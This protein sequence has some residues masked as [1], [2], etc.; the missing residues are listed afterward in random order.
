M[1]F[2]CCLFNFVFSI[3]QLFYFILKQRIQA[4]ELRISSLKTDIPTGD[5]PDWDVLYR[6]NE[7]GLSKTIV[8]NSVL[9]SETISMNKLALRH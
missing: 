3:A 6:S 8:E 4:V 1:N 2:F 7:I 5:N 9:I